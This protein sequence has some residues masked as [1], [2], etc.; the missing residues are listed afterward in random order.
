M[1]SRIIAFFS[2]AMF[3]FLCVEMH[4]YGLVTFVF[5]SLYLIGII[6]T[7]FHFSV[8]PDEIEQKLTD[9]SDRG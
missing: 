2:G 1:I 3:A 8:S 4:G 9:I 7:A 6:A 5:L